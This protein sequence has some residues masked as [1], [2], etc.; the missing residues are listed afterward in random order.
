M[1]S[2]LAKHCRDLHR[3]QDE[4]FP[5]FCTTPSLH[6]YASILCNLLSA[7]V[8]K[9]SRAV[10]ENEKQFQIPTQNHKAASTSVSPVQ[11]LPSLPRD[12]ETLL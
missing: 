11:Q 10:E 5:S 3:S 12:P 1:L 9:G 2:G 7:M 6:V 4:F 8:G